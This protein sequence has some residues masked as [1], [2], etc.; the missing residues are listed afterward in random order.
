M[1]DLKTGSDF[2]MELK[3]ARPDLVGKNG[4]CG[5]CATLIPILE[6]VQH[7]CEENEVFDIKKYM[8]LVGKEIPV[9]GRN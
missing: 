6:L 1:Q 3:E 2:K 9:S 7:K 5:K 4:I 8:K